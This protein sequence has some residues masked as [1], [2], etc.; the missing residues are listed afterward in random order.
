MNTSIAGFTDGGDV[1]LECGGGRQPAIAMQ[2]DM[3]RARRKRSAVIVAICAVLALACVGFVLALCGPGASATSSADADTASPSASRV[4]SAAN[5]EHANDRRLIEEAFPGSL[6]HADEDHHAARR[7]GRFHGGLVVPAKNTCTNPFTGESTAIPY[8]TQK[9]CEK[10]RCRPPTGKGKKWCV[11]TGDIK[12]AP[13]TIASSTSASTASWNGKT[14]TAKL[15]G[16]QQCCSAASYANPARTVRWSE[17]AEPAAAAREDRAVTVPCGVRVLLDASATLPKGL[18]VKGELRVPDEGK[19][20]DIDLGFL[21]NCGVLRAHL[22][23]GATTLTFTLTGHEKIAPDARPEKN[24]NGFSTKA[25]VTQGG[26]TD[27]QG[28]LCGERT[29]TTLAATADAGARELRLEEPVAWAVGTE[30]MVASTDFQG[31]QTEVATVSAVSDDGKTLSLAHALVYPHAGVAPITAEVAALTRNIKITSEAACAAI[32][33]KEASNKPM[34]GHTVVDHT[35]HATVCG[36]EM[37]RLGKHTTTG[38]Y[39]MHVHMAGDAPEIRVTHNAVHSNHHRALVLHGVSNATWAENVVFRSVGHLLLTED[40]GEEGNRIERNVLALPKRPSP[41]W[42]SQ[43]AG[44]VPSP[45]G[46]CEIHRCSHG[47]GIY[48]AVCGNRHDGETAAMWISNPYNHFVGNRIIAGRAVGVRFETRGTTGRISLLDEET[49]KLFREG[50]NKKTLGTFEG[51][52]IHSSKHGIFNYPSWNPGGGIRIENYV[53]W[54]NKNAIFA[55]TKWAYKNP[56]LAGDRCYNVTNATL[57]M[58]QV[59]VYTIHDDS[60]LHVSN[61]VIAP[62]LP[63]HLPLTARASRDK[64]ATGG[65]CASETVDAQQEGGL[66][67]SKDM[68]LRGGVDELDLGDGDGAT[69]SGAGEGIEFVEGARDSRTCRTAGGKWFKKTDNQFESYEWREAVAGADGTIARPFGDWYFKLEGNRYKGKT[70]KSSL[71][72]AR[73]PTC[74]ERVHTS[75][76]KNGAPDADY[77]MPTQPARCAGAMG[78]SPSVAP[79][80]SAPGA[81]ANHQF[82][83]YKAFREGKHSVAGL[84]WSITVDEASVAGAKRNGYTT[85]EQQGQW[86]GRPKIGLDGEP[87]DRLREAPLA[88]ASEGCY[89]QA[90]GMTGHLGSYNKAYI[91]YGSRKRH[92]FAI[93]FPTE[94]EVAEA[95]RAGEHD[96]CVAEGGAWELVFR[97]TR[98]FKYSPANDWQQARRHNADNPEADNFSVLDTLEG[99]RNAADNKFTLKL[100]YPQDPTIFDETHNGDATESKVKYQRSLR[101]FRQV[102]NPV[103]RRSAPYEFAAAPEQRWKCMNDAS[104]QKGDRKHKERLVVGGCGTEEPGRRREKTFENLFPTEWVPRAG[105]WR[106]L[107]YNGGNLLFIGGHTY[108]RFGAASYGDNGGSW[109]VGSNQK[110]GIMGGD[111]DAVKAVELHACRFVTEEQ[112]NDDEDAED[113]MNASPEDESAEDESAEDERAAEEARKAAEKAAEKAAKAEAEAARKAAKAKEHAERAERK[114]EHKRIKA[115]KMAAQKARKEAKRKAKESNQQKT[116]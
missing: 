96:T 7:L 30:V 94:A 91:H 75:T 86:G 44:V 40:G 113:E 39:P 101:V 116:K 97:Q 36:V 111:G 25:F 67:S 100:S 71:Q 28:S 72:L 22:P 89:L 57:L 108:R 23:S 3:K 78:S 68:C 19:T 52:V 43:C 14:V 10:A 51:N 74:A 45:Y 77:P 1:D 109:A 92:R 66:C 21:Y 46:G 58:N 70:G 47:T 63:A 38:K 54:K 114:A 37:T 53:A 106:G 35:D 105:K 11:W 65:A 15:G 99:Y 90:A 5:L 87:L 42:P 102:N 76:M 26:T 104:R 41:G 20:L 88:C 93:T 81:S 103:G 59:Q 62:Q 82:P 60:K 110:Y 13:E 69:G 50:A 12:H 61:S 84:P 48:E 112:A 85:W 55:K 64:I 49:L 16:A 56:N 31:T 18:I 4:L 8:K 95:Q 115:E 107:E 32:P 79:R 98:G 80:V 83:V 34:C 33:N 27:L 9:A 29:W 2:G 73:R 17:W 6:L 24:L